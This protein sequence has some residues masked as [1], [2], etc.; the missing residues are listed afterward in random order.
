MRTETSIADTVHFPNMASPSYSPKIAYFRVCAADFA[1]QTWR[2][3]R[4]V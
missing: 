3:H 1:A 2:H 4:V